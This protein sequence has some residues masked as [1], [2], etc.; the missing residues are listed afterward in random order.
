MSKTKTKGSNG[1]VDLGTA[2]RR[3]G[4]R[5]AEGVFWD[6]VEQQRL[7]DAQ[8]DE[9]FRAC[10]PKAPSLLHQIVKLWLLSIVFGLGMWYAHG[11]GHSLDFAVATASVIVVCA[12]TSVLATRSKFLRDGLD[13]GQDVAK[14]AGAAIRHGS[15]L[16]GVFAVGTIGGVVFLAA[17]GLE[18]SAAGVVALFILGLGAVKRWMPKMTKKNPG[19]GETAEAV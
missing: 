7:A 18:A 3:I 16:V 12:G 14:A 17:S 19:E 11:A 1:R 6:E 10:E 2:V 5:D 9:L 4:T 8:L 13:K 15:Y